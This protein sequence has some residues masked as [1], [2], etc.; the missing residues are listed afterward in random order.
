MSDAHNAPTRGSGGFRVGVPARSGSAARPAR[1][2]SSRA[3]LRAAGPTRHPPRT[4]LIA[5]G[6]PPAAG[7][8]GPARP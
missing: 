4:S 3:R 6:R 8:G 7:G 1:R 5:M 2:C